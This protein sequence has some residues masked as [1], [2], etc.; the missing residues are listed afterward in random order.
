MT[1]ETHELGEAK[2]IDQVTEFL[3][4]GNGSAT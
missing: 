1:N 2:A 4:I 3:D